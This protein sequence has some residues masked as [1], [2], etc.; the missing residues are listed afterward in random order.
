MQQSGNG[1]QL[2]CSRAGP[3]RMC[4][5]T[6]GSSNTS[7][8]RRMGSC[9]CW[10]SPHRGDRIKQPVARIVVGPYVTIIA[11]A[12]RSRREFGMTLH[13]CAFRRVVQ[14]PQEPLE[15]LAPHHLPDCDTSTRLPHVRCPFNLEETTLPDRFLGGQ[16]A[17]GAD[18]GNQ[19]LL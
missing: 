9:E 10:F 16:P 18:R 7:S 8:L 11:M 3:P 4:A 5:S 2:G 1:K 19:A 12:R 15:R 14:I 6:G 13:P 17:S